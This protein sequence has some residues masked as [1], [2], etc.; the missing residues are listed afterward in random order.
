M[1]KIPPQ[2]GDL[3]ISKRYQFSGA[4]KFTIYYPESA[5]AC[6]KERATGVPYEDNTIAYIV[7]K[8]CM[9]SVDEIDKQ[10]Y[11][12]IVKKIWKASNQI[13]EEEIKEDA[14]Y[15]KLLDY[16]STIAYLTGYCTLGVS[17][18][19]LVVFGKDMTDI[20]SFTGQYFDE[21]FC[22]RSL[23][24]KMWKYDKRKELGLKNP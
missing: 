10:V 18:D 7:Q 15:N 22:L 13:K 3:T 12:Y 20:L 17:E 6:L 19:D 2:Y 1:L 24:G 21:N 23:K 11:L 4:E 5:L 14:H 16:N 8:N 9:F